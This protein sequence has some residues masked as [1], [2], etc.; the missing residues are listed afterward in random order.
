[1][2]FY[3]TSSGG[4]SSK[5]TGARRRY[6]RRWI[7]G[8][9]KDPGFLGTAMEAVPEGDIRGLFRGGE[10]QDRIITPFSETQ[11]EGSQQLAGGFLAAGETMSTEDLEQKTRSSFA[12][13]LKNI[14]FP[15]IGDQVDRYSSGFGD[16]LAREG[17]GRAKEMEM[18]LAD[19][20]IAVDESAKSRSIDMMDRYNEYLAA[21]DPEQTQRQAEETAAYEEFQRSQSLWASIFAGV[22]TSANVSSSSYKSQAYL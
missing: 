5:P 2:A 11:I 20:R 12:F 19:R 13:D 16:A 7:G 17:T 14:L 21:A 8:K 6:E 3:S 1:M 4:S 10:Y 18:G 22:D 9:K 15:E